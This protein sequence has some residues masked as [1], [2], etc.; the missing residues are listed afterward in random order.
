L[1]KTLGK[2]AQ[3]REGDDNRLAM[4][5]H[6]GWSRNR[7]VW[8]L[9]PTKECMG[10]YTLIRENEDR[11]HAIDTGQVLRLLKSDEDSGLSHR[12]V[13]RRKL[14]FGPNELIERGGTS[15]WVILL[16]QF[17]STVVI[18][19][20]VGAIV[21]IGLGDFGDAIVIGI[22]VVLNALL[23]FNQEYRAE[24]AMATLKRIATPTVRVW[25]EGVLAEI[26]ARDLV[27]GDILVLE[28]GSLV[29]ADSRVLQSANLRIQESALTGE[30]EPVDKCR[31]AVSDEESALAE[32]TS[33]AFRG[34]TVTSGRGVA[35]VTATGMQTQ[36]GR[37]ASMIEE[38]HRG[39]TPLE[40]RLNHL[41]RTLVLAALSIVVLIFVLGLSRGEP[42]QLMLLTAVSIAI[43][44]VPEGLPAV[45][46]IAL[47][48]GSQR[49]LKRNALIRKLPAVETLGSVTVICSDKTGTLTENRMTVTELRAEGDRVYL[50]TATAKESQSLGSA[51]ELQ[52][53]RESPGLQFLLVGGALCNDAE[54]DA[55]DNTRAVGDPTEGA[56]VTAAARLGL[57]KDEIE[58]S[59]PRIAEIPFES[60]RKLM[61]TVHRVAASGLQSDLSLMG[62][63]LSTN[64]H[65]GITKGAVDNIAENSTHILTEGRIEAM[66][67]DARQWINRANAEMASSGMRVLGVAFR[68]LDSVP[69]TED[70]RGLERDLVFVGLIG[71]LD[72]PR[73]EAEEAVSRCKS[74]GI[75]TLMITGDHPLTARHIALELG[76][77]DDGPVVSGR[78]LA[79]AS[80]AELDRAVNDSAVFARVSPGHK[81]RIVQSL[82]RSGQIVAMTGDGVNDA[83]ALKK[84]NIGVAMGL[85][86]TDVAKE[87]ADMVLLDDNFAT[88]VAAIEEGRVIYD[89]VRKFVRYIL[90]TNSGE[91]W[92]MLL[93]PIIGMPLPLAPLQILWMNLVTD[94]LPAVALALEPAERNAMN[95]PPYDPAET[96]FGRGLGRHVIWVGLLMGLTS[97]IT[98]YIGWSNGLVEWQTIV[99]TTIT[100]SQMAHVMAIRSEND[101]LFRIGVFTNRSMVG[102][103]VLTIVFQIAIIYIPIL[104]RVFDTRPLTTISLVL[105]ILIS[106]LIFW[107]VE[108]EKLIRRRRQSRDV[109][110]NTTSRR[111]VKT[112][113]RPWGKAHKAGAGP[114]AETPAVHR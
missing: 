10:E 86:G 36:L 61:T 14:E 109:T 32:R 113:S 8:S 90:A 66:S 114:S 78:E 92:L 104:Q 100:F 30:S 44:A 69:A 112:Y 71:M 16:K 25:R 49:M 4:S 52:L 58:R 76:I 1:R 46:T 89:N 105:S 40:V 35:V 45:V 111:S 15:A 9:R 67:A 91:L 27:P 85:T 17:S 6:R 93:A 107:A 33:M 26:S 64:S 38:V 56:L 54:V 87:A 51:D 11:W 102:A 53:V 3:F 42:F 84:A 81:L 5:R 34:T 19:L 95:R 82:Q 12:E 7:T 101:S 108:L 110:R 70:L 23:G 41:G 18:V 96:I 28:A 73:K 29:A 62:G 2:T 99:F 80:E 22:I 37:I 77:A 72:R 31:Q 98:G 57:S 75:R 106:S 60:E 68:L 103:V 94:G 79:T 48:L 83:P 21:S 88:I 43:A 20:I 65:L 39:A 13:E 97:V 50:Q 63:I 59:L 74:A 24:K 47:S 55:R